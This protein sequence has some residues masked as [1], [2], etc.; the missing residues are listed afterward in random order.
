MEQTDEL[1]FFYDDFQFNYNDGNSFGIYDH[2]I[3]IPEHP[4]EDLFSLFR[5]ETGYRKG[6]WNS[7]LMKLPVPVIYSENVDCGVLYNTRDGWIKHDDFSFLD[8]ITE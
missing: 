7:K 1:N 6:I 4:T 3:E 5:S 8:N 2:E